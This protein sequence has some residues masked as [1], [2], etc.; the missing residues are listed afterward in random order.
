M[1]LN[2]HPCVTV[3]SAMVKYDSVLY[4]EYVIYVMNDPFEKTEH[5][6]VT[7]TQ[8]TSWLSDSLY[9]KLARRRKKPLSSRL[10]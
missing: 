5:I 2:K 7:Q 6:T 10:C 8:I 3:P 9:S 1:K 4:N